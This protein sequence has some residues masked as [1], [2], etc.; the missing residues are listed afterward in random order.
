[1][2]K[3][4]KFK[5]NTYLDSSSIVHNK[6][7]FAEKF[8]EGLVNVA[9]NMING[10]WMKLCNIHFDSHVQ[11]EFVYMKIMIGNGNNGLPNQNAYIDLIMQLGWTGSESGRLGCSAILHSIQTAFTTTNTSLKVIANS[12]IDYDIWFRASAIYCRPNYVFEGSQRVRVIP[13]WVFSD[14]EP[15]GTE[16][17]LA[18]TN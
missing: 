13:K 7:Y 3:A 6:H 17:K 2:S 1:M 5:N 8:Q 18:Y 15:S 9:S 14:S 12:N 4:I 10:K 16:C 11:G